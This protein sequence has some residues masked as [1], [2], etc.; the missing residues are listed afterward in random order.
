MYNSDTVKFSYIDIDTVKSSD[1]IIDIDFALQM[2]LLSMYHFGHL[3][4][5]GALGRRRVL[6]R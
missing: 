4:E 2:Y 6:S 3:T 5:V 1:I